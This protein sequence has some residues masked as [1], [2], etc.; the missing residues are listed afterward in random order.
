MELKEDINTICYNQP[1]SDLVLLLKESQ[2]ANSVNFNN[3]WTSL[4]LLAKMM[5]MD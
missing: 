1:S 5:S 3:S 4:M 2:M